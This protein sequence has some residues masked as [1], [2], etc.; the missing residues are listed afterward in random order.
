M[1]AILKNSCTLEPLTLSACSKSW[2]KAL[3][4]LNNSY[5]VN[6]SPNYSQSKARDSFSIRFHL[7]YTLM[8][9]IVKNGCNFG[10]NSARCM[11]LVLIESS[12][13]FEQL[14]FQAVFFYLFTKYGQRQFFI[15]SM[16]LWRPSWKMAARGRIHDGPISKFVRNRLDYLYTKFGAFIKKCTIGLNIQGKQPRY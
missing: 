2:L 4:I 14:L 10:T 6:L 13:D 5:S 1:A 3:M 11:F 12:D 9:A 15:Y 8:A 7:Q 16:R